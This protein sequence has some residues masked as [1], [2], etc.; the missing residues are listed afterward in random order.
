MPSDS[1]FFAS[2]LHRALVKNF[3]ATCLLMPS[4]V[5]H[6]ESQSCWEGRRDEGHVFFFVNLP[7]LMV[8]FPV[9]LRH[10]RRL[11]GWGFGTNANPG[12]MSLADRK[13]GAILQQL[14]EK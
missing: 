2:P 8:W 5:E 14:P 12:F 9:H 7:I 11:L 6:A 4:K 10:V 3:A 13:G 1:E